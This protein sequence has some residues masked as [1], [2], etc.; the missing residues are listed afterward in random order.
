MENLLVGKRLINQRHILSDLIYAK[1]LE[2]N[3]TIIAMEFKYKEDVS[4]MF[5][6]LGTSYEFQDEA[7]F[8]NFMQWFGDLGKHLGFNM[9]KMKEVFYL[10]E[11]ELLEFLDQSNLDMLDVFRKG[12]VV[13]EDSYN[14]LFIE[15]IEDDIFLNYLVNMK[16]NL[17]EKY[18][19]D[20]M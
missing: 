12:C 15:E 13:Y 19:M 11:Q 6:Y 20:Y 16:S 5:E 1:D 18:V 17:A 14:D 2:K 10:I 3:P 8:T 4:Y 9:I 7:I